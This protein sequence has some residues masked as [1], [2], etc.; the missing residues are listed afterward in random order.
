MFEKIYLVHFLAIR[1]AMALLTNNLIMLGRSIQSFR[2]LQHQNGFSISDS[3][4]R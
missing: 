3:R 2:H 4:G 1:E